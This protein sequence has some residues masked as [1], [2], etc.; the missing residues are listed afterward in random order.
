MSIGKMSLDQ[1]ILHL[2]GVHQVPDQASMLEL[3]AQEGFQ[4][5]QGTLS[6]RLAKLS[7]QKRE[8]HY[9]R[10]IPHDH[11][12]PPYTLMESPPNLLVLQTGPGFGM[13][14]AIRVDRSLLPGI[15]GTIAGEDTLLIAIAQGHEL[16][17]VRARVEKVL[18]LPQ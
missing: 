3:L 6:R 4:L 11:P 18:G 5:T 14:L 12:M 7:V 13:A 1:A 2:I 15:A 8:G 9:Q 17:E 16:A 10:V